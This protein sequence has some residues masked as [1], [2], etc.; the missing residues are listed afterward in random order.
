MGHSNE[1]QAESLN[2][3][4][5]SARSRPLLYNAVLS[6]LETMSHDHN[7]IELS[8]TPRTGHL[9]RGRACA[10]AHARISGTSL[11]SQA[12]SGSSGRAAIR[13]ESSQVA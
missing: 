2:K 1:N 9:M 4:L 3:T 7:K 12:T 8:S 6:E 13:H 10:R 5:L 11:R